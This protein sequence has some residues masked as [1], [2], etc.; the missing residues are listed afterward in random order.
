LNSNITYRQI[1]KS[2]DGSDNF[3]SGHQIITVRQGKKRS[4]PE[5]VSDDEKFKDFLLRVF[6]KMQEDEKQRLRAGRLTRIFYMHYRANLTYGDIAYELGIT[7][8]SVERT[9][10]RI[11]SIAEGKWS[12]GKGKHGLRP[13]GRPKKMVGVLLNSGGIRTSFAEVQNLESHDDRIDS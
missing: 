4:V 5:W 10:H 7:T 8:K 9:L 2:F 13:R 12:N 6:P 3:A 1:R 11:R